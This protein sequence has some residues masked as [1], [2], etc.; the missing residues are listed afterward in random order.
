MTLAEKINL[1]LILGTLV[2]TIISFFIN[3]NQLR[4][5]NLELE[6]IK[7][8]NSNESRLT[9]LEIDY[10]FESYTELS[11]YIALL[12]RS[13]RRLQPTKVLE[14]G[15]SEAEL[16]EMYM[17][18]Y[19]NAMSANNRFMEEL[20][21]RTPFIDK[22]VIDKFFL[23]AYDCYKSIEFFLKLKDK[24]C[25]RT[26][27]N[28]QQYKQYMNN[29]DG[30]LEKQKNLNNFIYTYI[31]WQKSCLSDGMDIRDAEI[32]KFPNIEDY[33]QNLM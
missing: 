16:S 18:M 25:K 3:R 29:L 4:K 33:Y 8:F 28:D 21:N 31:K 20:Y 5:Q 30:L 27:H 11:K 6:K 23:L 1:I 9:Q 22:R 7:K 15:S 19:D 17:K 24:L 32:V 14:N 12:F 26:Y 13:T 2:W 10:Q